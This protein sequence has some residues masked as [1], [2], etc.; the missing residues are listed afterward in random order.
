MFCPVCE[1]EY[2]AGITHCSEDNSPLVE[3]LSPENALHDSSE[4]Q[5]VLLHRMGSPAEAEMVNELLSKNGV[6]TV[7]KAGGADAFLQAREMMVRPIPSSA[8]RWELGVG[9]Y[10]R[11]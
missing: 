2:E 9:S 8:R 10:Q 6:R 11:S 3:K 7:V 1:A 5:F 4:A